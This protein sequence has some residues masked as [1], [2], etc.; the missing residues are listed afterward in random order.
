M[1]AHIWRKTNGKKVWYEWCVTSPVTT[2]IHN[3]SGESYYI[4]L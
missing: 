4:G 1:E 2:K 3:A